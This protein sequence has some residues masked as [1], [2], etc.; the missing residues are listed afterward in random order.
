MSSRS[1]HPRRLRALPDPEQIAQAPESDWARPAR[2]R[3]RLIDDRPRILVAGGDT[4]RRLLLS[5]ELALAGED[6]VVVE[7]RELWEVL[8]SAPQCDAILLAGD[9]DDAPQASLRRLLAHRHP[10]L[11]ELTLEQVL[12]ARR[13]RSAGVAS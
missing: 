3:L 9:L 12:A 8:E 13:A 2:P 7:A 6:T 11:R 1:Q 5:S 10:G 4:M